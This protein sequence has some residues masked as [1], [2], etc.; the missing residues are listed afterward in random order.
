MYLLKET[1]IKFKTMVRYISRS[2][3]VPRVAGCIEGRERETLTTNGL[4]R[5]FLKIMAI[6]LIVG[7]QQC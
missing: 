7:S 4:N 2:L 5:R 1:P 6:E 3:R